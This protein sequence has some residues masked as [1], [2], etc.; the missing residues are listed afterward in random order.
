MFPPPDTQNVN[1]SNNKNSKQ[2]MGV[3]SYLTATLQLV[4]K[5]HVLIESEGSVP[6]LQES[7]DIY[8]KAKLRLTENL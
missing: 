7:R 8:W 3:G 2:P 1:I 4:K 5:F 6:C